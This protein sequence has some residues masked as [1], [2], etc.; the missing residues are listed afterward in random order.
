[1]FNKTLVI[2][3]NTTGTKET[4]DNGFKLTGK[5]I[6]VRYSTDN[7]LAKRMLEVITFTEKQYNDYIEN[8][9]IAGEKLYTTK[10]CAESIYKYF[11]FVI[12]N[13]NK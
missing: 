5:E 4:F 12:K 8:A 2:G 10:A 1:M 6:G 3:R 11:D 7:E 9:S 13:E